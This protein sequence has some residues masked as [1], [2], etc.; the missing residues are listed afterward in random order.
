MGKFQRRREYTKNVGKLK[1]LVEI[2][3]EF[4]GVTIWVLS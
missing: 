3:G 2:R 1:K 4:R